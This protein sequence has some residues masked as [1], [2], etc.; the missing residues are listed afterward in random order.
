MQEERR[1]AGI[2]Q[3]CEFSQLAEFR[4]LRIFAGSQPAK[5]AQPAL[6]AVLTSF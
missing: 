1:A 5:I 6:F 3:C 4:R 2:L